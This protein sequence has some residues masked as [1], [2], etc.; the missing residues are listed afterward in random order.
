MSD[1]GFTSIQIGDGLLLLIIVQLFRIT[2]KI[3]KMNNFKE[4]IEDRCPLFKDNR[5]KK[6]RG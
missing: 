2:K 4:R 1:L 3:A 6:K 5:N